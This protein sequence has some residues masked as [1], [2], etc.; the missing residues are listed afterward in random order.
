MTKSPPRAFCVDGHQMSVPVSEEVAEAIQRWSV[1]H[2]DD[3]VAA[4]APLGVHPYELLVPEW[5]RLVNLDDI[6]EMHEQATSE[7]AVLAEDDR[8]RS[9]LKAAGVRYIPDS[10]VYAVRD[11]ARAGVVEVKEP[12]DD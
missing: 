10:T 11:L 3:L 9:W 5:R 7:R 8:I 12:T 1:A 4:L 6:D 2:H